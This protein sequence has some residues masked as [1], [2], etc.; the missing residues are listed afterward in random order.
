MEAQGSAALLSDGGVH[1]F[2]DNDFADNVHLLLEEHHIPGMSIAVVDNG[3]ASAKGY[4]LARFPDI[5]ATP[6]TLYYAGS[7]TKAMLAAATGVLIHGPKDQSNPLLSTLQ[8]NRWATT[9]RSLLPG[10][11]GLNDEYVAANITIEDAL[12]HRTGLSGADFMY[13]N[14]MSNDPGLIVQAMPHIGCLTKPFRTAWQYN[15]LMYS[16][17]ADTLKAVTALD[18]GALLKKLLWDPLGMTSTFW[19]LEEIP[20]DKQENDLARGYYWVGNDQSQQKQEEGYFV[21]EPYLEF[22]GIAP[23]GAVISSV[24]DYSSWIS[25]LLDAA[26]QVKDTRN[27]GGQHVI[28]PELFGEL[29][30]ARS[31]LFEPPMGDHNQHRAYALGWALAPP[32]CGIHH[33][34]IFHAGGLNGFGTQLYLLPNDSF[35]VVTLGN[36][37][38]SSN[39]VGDAIC[40]NLIGKKLGLHGADRT[41]FVES[42]RSK[43]PP[44][45][46]PE[47]ASKPE[48]EELADSAPAIGA[49][50][51]RLLQSLVGEYE[52]PAFG[53]FRV[54]V[55]ESVR[56]DRPILYL[57]WVSHSD[58]AERDKRR[59][60]LP[61]LS[62]EPVGSRTW[63]YWLLLHP[64][65]DVDQCVEDMVSRRNENSK[66]LFFDLENLN[67]HGNTE[68]DALLGLPRGDERPDRAQIMRDEVVWNSNGWS[69]KGAALKLTTAAAQLAKSNPVSCT[70]G[71]RLL[72]ELIGKDGDEE[73]GWEQQ[74]VW[75]HRVASEL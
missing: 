31:M 44:D 26:K 22:A 60:Q 2:L 75:F 10:K 57:P 36:T 20:P 41:K 39:I 71:M 54:S 58:R 25:E 16:V 47:M 37:A 4:G 17:V 13:G 65:S 14:W 5:A 35:G 40:L 12:S 62:V 43:L 38:V 67:A 45:A 21:P 74:M 70:L 50:A 52:H 33:P 55:Y 18:C 27:S 69:Q 73:A 46:V 49:D 8:H 32:V 9:I 68:D 34:I 11:W 28:T 23:A 15:N 1:H 3:R 42:I 19:R 61:C 6:N 59:N 48:Q 7:T 51:Q 24:M 53:H 72:S 66:T 63:K 56:Q 64:R 30:T 29:T